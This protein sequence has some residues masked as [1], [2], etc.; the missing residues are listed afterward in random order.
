[1][2]LDLDPMP[3]KFVLCVICAGACMMPNAASIA[4]CSG[5]V[6]GAN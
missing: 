4:L 2:A 3:R 1:M 6:V 5:G